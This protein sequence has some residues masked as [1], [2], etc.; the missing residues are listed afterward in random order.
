MRF[1][2]TRKPKKTENKVTVGTYLGSSLGACL[3]IWITNTWWPEILAPFQTF[4]APFWTVKGTVQEWFLAV[5]PMFVWGCGVTAVLQAVQNSRYKHSFERFLRFGRSDPTAGEILGVGTLLSLW[6]G[7]MEELAFRWLMYLSAI[8]GLV[9]MNWLWGT[10]FAYFIL[11]FFGILLTALAANVSS[12][13]NNIPAIVTGLACIAGIVAL[14]VHGLDFNPVKWFYEV[15]WLPLADFTSFGKMHA[16]LYQPYSWT[17]GAAVV[18]VNCLFRDGH[19]YQGWLGYINSWFLGLVFF[20]MMF[21]YGLVAA[22]AA[23]F[24]YNFLIYAVHAAER[25]LPRR[26]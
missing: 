14:A 23:H 4:G 26:R 25:L 12:R 19:K 1:T 9:F 6:A 24:L 22:M 11:V 20:W 7:I 17:L 2:I 5:W 16:I 18:S 21:T 13:N 15:L 8:V 10:A 3:V